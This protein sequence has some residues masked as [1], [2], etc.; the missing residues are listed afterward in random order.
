MIRLNNINNIY[1]TL[2]SFLLLGGKLMI[3]CLRHL[4]D[5][6]NIDWIGLKSAVYVNNSVIDFCHNTKLSTAK[7]SVWD[8]LTLPKLCFAKSLLRRLE[9]D[10]S[11]CNSNRSYASL[12]NEYLYYVNF[13]TRSVI[14]R[15][16][17]S[18]MFEV[19]RRP[20]RAR[21]F[22]LFTNI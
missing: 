10:Q 6:K 4:K 17:R 7:V 15:R 12:V 13:E 3:T 11:Q 16:R 19:R 8:R 21:V 5:K 22:C 9:C 14:K 18:H 1:F 20:T 2:C